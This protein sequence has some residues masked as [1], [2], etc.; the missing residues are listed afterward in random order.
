MTSVT[1]NIQSNIHLSIKNMH[2]EGRTII[3]ITNVI[4]NKQHVKMKM[5]DKVQ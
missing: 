5:R 1:T 4:T 3:T 2:M